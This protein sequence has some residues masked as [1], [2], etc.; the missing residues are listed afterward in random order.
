MPRFGKGNA[1]AADGKL[2]ISMMDGNVI[3][4][5]LNQDEYQEL[6]RQKVTRGTRQAPSLSDGLL[7]LRD[8]ESIYAIDISGN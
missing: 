6:G 8:D 7:F 4:A 1:I 5:N 3:I 2:F